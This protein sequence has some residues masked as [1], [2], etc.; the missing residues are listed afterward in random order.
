MTI[1]DDNNVKKVTI[2]LTKIGRTFKNFDQTDI[3]DLIFKILSLLY[4][5]IVGSVNALNMQAAAKQQQQQNLS[6]VK[7]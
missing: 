5:R 6:H 7:S 3:H 2:R 4:L 1:N